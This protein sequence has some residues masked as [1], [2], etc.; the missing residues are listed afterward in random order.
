MILVRFRR[1][2]YRRANLHTIFNCVNCLKMPPTTKTA[3]RFAKQKVVARFVDPSGAVVAREIEIR[4]NP[5][6]GRTSRIAFS[7]TGE[8][9]AGTERLPDP[10]PDALETTACPFCRPQVNT[11]TPRLHERLSK[12]ARLEQGA[13]ILFPN[14]FPYGTY[15]AVS[16][17]DNTH[18]AEI[19]TATSESYTDSFLNAA[20]YLKK[21][22]QQDPEAFYMAITQNHLPS[23][24]GSLLHPHLQINADPI[25]SNHHRFLA[26][27]TQ[28]YFET[29]NQRLFEDYLSR[30]REDGCRFIGQT[31]PWHWMAAYAPEGF[32]EI[33]GIFPGV[34]SIAKLTESDWQALAQGVCQTQ[35]FYR[36]L[37]RNGYNLGLLTIEK[38]RSHLELRITLMVR[39]NH[40]PWVRNDHTGFEVMLGDMA[41]FTAPE[42]TAAMARPFWTL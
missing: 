7:R 33:W 21:I 20:I 8:K 18:F 10:P 16:L 39:S 26:Q 40:A 2:N 35:K 3:L 11:Q 28:A 22:K 38:D 30:E 25:P 24:G 12:K 32:F 41:T 14:L 5:I 37:N 34:T 15:S 17:I 36:S 27:R 13:S 19:G 1:I 31:G 4:T 29:H 6:S 42:E 23:A 9:E